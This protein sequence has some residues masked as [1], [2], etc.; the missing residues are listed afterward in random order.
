MDVMQVFALVCNGIPSVLP[1]IKLLI[2]FTKVET[3]QGQT[4]IFITA[5]QRLPSFVFFIMYL[6][7]TSAS[8]C[9][10]IAS[11]WYLPHLPENHNQ[12]DQLKMYS[13]M[14]LNCI[15]MSLTKWIINQTDRNKSWCIVFFISDRSDIHT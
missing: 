10:F 11:P 3:G 1:Y 2:G 12:W 8:L 4:L 9:I 5:P 15:K 13:S 6:T 14:F 7:P